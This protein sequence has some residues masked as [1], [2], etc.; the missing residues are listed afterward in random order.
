[1]QNNEKSRIVFIALAAMTL[2]LT[3][4][5]A[6]QTGYVV[7]DY[8]E[9]QGNTRKWAEQHTQ[10]IAKDLSNK[11]IQTSTIADELA[12]RISEADCSPCDIENNLR[13]MY[14]QH[15]DF[16]A[17]GVAF[18]AGQSGTGLHLYAP[19]IRE[20]S[21]A[22]AIDRLDKYYDYLANSAGFTSA[23]SSVASATKSSVQPSAQNAD[24]LDN[25]ELWYQ[26]AQVK[27]QQWLGPFYE[28]GYNHY[29]IRYS[30]PIYNAKQQKI[31]V[32]FVDVSLD[33][34]HNQIE[35]YDIK[36]NNYLRLISPQG[37]ELY[38]SLNSMDKTIKNLRTRSENIPAGSSTTINDLTKG[39]AWQNS[40]TISA[41]Q[42]HLISVIAKATL[43]DVALADIALADTDS[44][45]EKNNGKNSGHSLQKLTKNNSVGWV[46]VLV[47]AAF[48]YYTLWRLYRKR[49]SK[50]QL[51]LDTAIYTL[52]LMTGVIS[53]WILEYGSIIEAKD[54]PLILANKAII[55][56]FEREYALRALALHQEAP[57]FVR[58]G[59]FI[60]SIEFISATNVNITG[61]V[62]HR[63]QA[64]QD[65]D[66]K[67]GTLFP[68]AI[69]TR[70]NAAYERKTG[71]ETLKGWYFETTL[72]ENFTPERFP[73]DRQS[74]WIR[75]WHE[76]I[77]ENIVLVP[78][79]K[80]YDNLDTRA[81]PGLEKDF[82]LSGWSLFRSYFDMHENTYNTR[83]GMENNSSDTV[84]EL[85]FNI[86]IMRN[87]INPFLAHLFPLLV[88]VL[89]LY[90]IVI[91]MSTDE[92]KKDF[93]GFN[94]AGVVASCSAL[95]FVALVSHMQMRDE[96]KSNAVVYLEYF[97]LITY[98]IILL[99]TANA[100]LL[101]LKVQVAFVQFHDNL[102]PKLLYWPAISSA[103]FLCTLWE[104]R[105]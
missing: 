73:L 29:I 33:W 37:S 11:M 17:L 31:G 64:G 98:V 43:V 68:E 74:V 87:F 85:Y 53:I 5:I 84:S 78:D 94:A 28:A 34:L 63:Y 16:F 76:K 101:S 6:I 100:I 72:R 99:I 48:F 15:T 21:A 23:Q 39:P 26:I 89:M 58:V 12:K 44:I 19:F 71:G 41:T 62:W 59:L 27:E 35:K 47:L 9:E 46:S 91:T 45:A 49:T 105:N 1:M 81:L 2:V 60:Q 70:I 57:I 88:V 95:F 103:L 93:L 77:G 56:K 86:E 92:T 30:T 90:A 8:Q 4:F 102:W 66:H 14:L 18:N 55:E 82:V 42:W 7:M 36:D 65:S 38:H 80:A 10:K 83:L 54:K 22:T 97:Y 67:I 96:L 25:A 40:T 20:N 50:L 75:L 32:A 24:I 51:W 52:I 79:L 69:E 3:I 13:A 104:F 61:Y